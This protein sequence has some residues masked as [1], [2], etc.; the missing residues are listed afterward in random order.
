MIKIQ[1]AD[2]TL[3][4]PCS[5]FYMGHMH[6]YSFVSF[7]GCFYKSVIPS[8]EIWIKL[9]FTW[10]HFYF[11]KGKLIYIAVISEPELEVDVFRYNK[12]YMEQSEVR[13]P[14]LCKNHTFVFN[15]DLILHVAIKGHLYCWIVDNLS[16][17]KSLVSVANKAL[18]LICSRISQ[19][20]LS[21]ITNT[22]RGKDRN[23][24]N[25]CF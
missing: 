13:E 24:W 22:C 3:L 17:K 14:L 7:F 23:L 11:W 2:S 21:I 6:W 16:F 25:K 20:I 8:I 10:H 19:Q 4:Y 9:L 1:K 18:F 12:D 15:L 5:T